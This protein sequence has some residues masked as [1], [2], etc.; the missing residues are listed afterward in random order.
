M[1]LF[2]KIFAIACLSS[3]AACPG[4]AQAAD[5][6]AAVQAFLANLEH[7]TAAK[8]SYE[9]LKDDGNGNVSITNLTLAKPEQGQEPAFT[10]KVGAADFSGITEEGPSHYQIGKASFANTTLEMKGKDVDLTA[11]V[12]NS[13]V[14]GWHIRPVGAQPTPQDELLAA[15]TF[16]KQMSSGPIAITAGGQK[17]SIDGVETTWNGD[18]NTGAGSFTLKV[19]NIALPESLVSL[20]DEGGMLKQLGYTSLNLDIASQGDLTL[21]G[22]KL[23][24]SFNAGLT[25]RNIASLSIGASVDDVPLAAYAE[26]MKAQSAGKDINLDALMPQLQGVQL[27]S[28][29]LRFA[30]ASL[31]GKLLPLLAASQGLDEK[32]LLASIPPMIQLQLIQLQNEAFTKQVVDAVT[33]FLNDPKSLTISAKPAAPVKISDIG[34]LDPAK[35]ADAITK[36][37][38]SV[39]A[40]E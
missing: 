9:A 22:D 3:V 27:K 40:N 36:L 29:N 35:P 2:H 7:Q 8:P 28:A 23:G 26:I 33:A 14:E 31:I 4:I 16:A 39:T 32:T 24:Y 10:L 1:R 15:S 12:P 38:I 18:A 20:L 13:S 25:G 6:T 17:L 11:S 30:D 21:N 19:N 34:A 5:A 37:G